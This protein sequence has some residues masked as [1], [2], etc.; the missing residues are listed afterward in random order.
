MAEKNSTKRHP[1]FIDLTGKTF[2][3]WTVLEFHSYNNRGSVKWLCRC[4]CGTEKPVITADLRRG[5]STQCTRCARTRH[6]VSRSPEWNS[7]AAMRKRC[8]NPSYGNYHRYGGRNIV[9]CDRWLKSFVNFLADMGP[10]PSSKHTI[11]RIDNDGNYEPSN[12][13]WATPKQQS[14]NKSTN[15]LVTHNGRTMCLVEW[16]EE[17][18]IG[19]VTLYCRLQSGWSIKQVLTTPARPKKQKSC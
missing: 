5:R 7:W 2:G 6:G 17:T 3:K 18:G 8:S 16:A 19:F 12:C 9:V 10:K 11:D 13:R 15:H 14:R 1:S 4:E